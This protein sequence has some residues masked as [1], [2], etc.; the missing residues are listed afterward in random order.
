M[1][2]WKIPISALDKATFS[3]P[4]I[5]GKTLNIFWGGIKTTKIAV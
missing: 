3:G 5:F 1:V 2:I 4:K